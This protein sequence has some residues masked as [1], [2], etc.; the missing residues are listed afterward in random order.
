[1][2]DR[3]ITYIY[4][5]SLAASPNNPGIVSLNVPGNSLVGGIDQFLRFT[6]TQ[7]CTQNNVY[8]ISPDNNTLTIAGVSY[9]IEPGFYTMGALA[10]HINSLQNS[11]SLSFNPRQ[12][13]YAFTKLSAAL[14]VSISLQGKLRQVLGCD[15]S[16]VLGSSVFTS[17]YCVL[18]NPVVDL[19]I[20]ITDVLLDPPTNLYC[21]GANLETSNI[22]AVVPL[23]ARPGCMNT[24]YNLNNSYTIDIF[25]TDVQNM[26]LF[27]TDA[28]GSPIPGLSHWTAVIKCERV[29]RA[30]LDPKLCMLQAIAEYSRLSFMQSALRDGYN[31]AAESQ[32]MLNEARYI[33]SA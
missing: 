10:T 11:V 24:W 33:D 18:P 13:K 15:G 6:F 8:N 3:N 31:D 22:F 23:R 29:D 5:S 19:V 20:R 2:S 26:T 27:V 28:D 14:S 21:A 17:P 9:A 4:V 30:S 1:M 12:N 16:F 32:T 7:M 25:D